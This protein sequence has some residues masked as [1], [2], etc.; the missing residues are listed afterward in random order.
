MAEENARVA[1]DQRYRE[2]SHSSSAPD[3]FLLSAYDEFIEPLFPKGGNAIDLAGGVGR[4]SLYLAARGWRVRLI[5][6]SAE[7]LKLARREADERGLAI[8]TEQADLT[9]WP[10]PR[11]AFDLV[12]NFFYLER[13]L[14]PQIERALQPSGLVVFKTYTRAQLSIGGGPSHPMHLLEANE[15]LKVF[16]CLRVLHYHE[17]IKDKATAELVAQ[18]TRPEENEQMPE[19]AFTTS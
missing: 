8:T 13:T 18:Q 12:L 6:V 15:P 3:P 9:E 14:F 7:A 16:S 11:S 2:R 17:S 1:W 4:H 19:A 5:D 10:L